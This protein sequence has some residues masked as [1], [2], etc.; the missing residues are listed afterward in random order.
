[1]GHTSESRKRAYEK[2]KTRKNEWFKNNGPCKRCG[3]W[4]KLE[5]DHIDRNTKQH[6]A[7]WSW[8]QQRRE[9]ELAKCQVLCNSCH[10]IKTASEN[11]RHGISRY[12]Y[13]CRCDICRKAK[14]DR[15]HSWRIS[16]WGS[17]S[18]KPKKDRLR[19]QVRE[20]Q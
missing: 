16:K 8:S 20:R 1:M 5:L 14:L 2:I 4:E 6:H 3:S 19:N 12:D 18:S 15:V 11:M 13:G 17:I 10:K 7:I 9:V